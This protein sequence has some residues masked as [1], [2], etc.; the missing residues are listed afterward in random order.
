MNKWKKIRFA[1]KIVVVC[2]ICIILYII[3]DL[4]LFKTNLQEPEITPY[5]F[6]FFGG[7]LMI[8]AA[9]RIFADSKTNKIEEKKEDDN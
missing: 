5:V 7:E 8:L 6:G 2:I 4:I 1:T 9:K 3:V